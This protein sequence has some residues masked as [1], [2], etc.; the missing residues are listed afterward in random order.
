MAKSETVY[1]VDDDESVLKPITKVVEAIGLRPE[2]YTSPEEFLEKCNPTGPACLVLDIM[3][4]EFKR[5]GASTEACSGWY[6]AAHGR[7]QRSC[8]RSA[9]RAVNAKRC[10]ERP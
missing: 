1:I 5:R 8:G 4:P 6:Q 7:H 10:L 2:T 9:Y 3:M